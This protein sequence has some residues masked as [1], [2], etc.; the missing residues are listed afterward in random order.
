MWKNNNKSKDGDANE[1]KVERT[2]KKLVRSSPEGA[3]RRTRWRDNLICARRLP[4]REKERG[5]TSLW[6]IGEKKWDR[7]REKELSTEIPRGRSTHC[8][9][10][11]LTE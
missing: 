7:M 11:Q 10:V 9:N 4:G 8:D 6:N 2:E 5:K 1:K 3:A